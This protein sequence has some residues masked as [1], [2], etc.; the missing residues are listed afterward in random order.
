MQKP[1]AMPASTLLAGKIAVGASWLIALGALALAPADSSWHSIGFWLTAF[2][3]GSHAL[4]LLVY[5]PF[6]KA[7]K[8]TGADY[9]Q[10]FLFGIFHSSGLKA[11][12]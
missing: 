5:G 2:L 12:D 10:V 11:G 8:A 1:P 6:L 9:L 7:A 4:E 3:A